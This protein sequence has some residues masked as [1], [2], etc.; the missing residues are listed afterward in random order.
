MEARKRSAWPASERENLF[1]NLP[2]CSGPVH[3]N[4]GKACKTLAI[5]IVEE[6]ISLTICRNSDGQE[7]FNSDLQ[8]ALR[9][10]ETLD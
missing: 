1:Y 3:A 6:T 5:E 2:G 7:T 4:S 8:R 9:S 10:A